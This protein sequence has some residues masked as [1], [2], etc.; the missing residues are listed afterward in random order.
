MLAPSM[1]TKFQDIYIVY[2]Y[3]VY[4]TTSVII[5]YEYVKITKLGTVLDN[6]NYS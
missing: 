1:V 4:S 6:I 2:V 3:Y 5:L